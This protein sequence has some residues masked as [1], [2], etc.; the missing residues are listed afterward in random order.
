MERNNIKHIYEEHLSAFTVEYTHVLEWHIPPK[1]TTTVKLKIA[2]DL[3]MHCL[4]I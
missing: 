3:L 2:E 1:R 4:K